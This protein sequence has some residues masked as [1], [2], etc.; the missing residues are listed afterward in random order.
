MEDVVLADVSMRGR[1][2]AQA[3]C[4]EEVCSNMFDVNGI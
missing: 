1:M 3:P 2:F 4:V